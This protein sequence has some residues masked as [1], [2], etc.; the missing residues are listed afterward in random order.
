MTGFKA[1]PDELRI[2]EYETEQPPAIFPF[3]EK[4]AG[5]YITSGLIMASRMSDCTYMGC[6]AS[7]L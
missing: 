2:H 6:E 4:V 3:I 5:K 1:I 7:I